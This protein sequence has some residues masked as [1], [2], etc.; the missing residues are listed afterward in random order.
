MARI[1]GKDIYLKDDDQ[2][3]FGDN[4]EAALWFDDGK[5]QLDSTISGVS[6]TESYHLATKEYVDLVG[7]DKSFIDG[8]DVYFYDETRNKT[9]GVSVIKIGGGRD[10]SNTTNQYLRT[11]DGQ[12]FNQSGISLPF[13]STIVG[14][15]MSC[16]VNTQSWTAQV[17]RNG[18]ATVLDSLSIN[19]TYQNYDWSR[20]VDFSAG[21]RIQIYLSGTNI[22]YPL[23]EVYFR[24]RK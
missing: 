18:V 2:I 1:K 12:P 17:R 20:N 22:S 6:P 10:H 4:K 21:D 3:Y 24:R 11:Y 13:D 5:L 16:S 23:V 19:N 14:I 7:S 8:D 15:T 9:L